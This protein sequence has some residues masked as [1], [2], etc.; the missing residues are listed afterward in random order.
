MVGDL[1]FEGLGGKV[2]LQQ[3]VVCQDELADMMFFL[4]EQ[5]YMNGS[6]NVMDGGI[7]CHVGIMDV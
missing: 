4:I 7:T 6:V 2:R 1:L 5:G 3:L